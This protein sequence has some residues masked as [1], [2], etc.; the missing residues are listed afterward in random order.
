[1][2]SWKNERNYISIPEKFIYGA[3]GPGTAWKAVV[4]EH[5]KTTRNQAR[6]YEFTTIHN[7]LV[8]VDV[9]MCQRN[10]RTLKALKRV[11]YH[12]LM[13][14]DEFSIANDRPNFI[15]R[16]IPEISSTVLVLLWVCFWHSSESI[17]QT[18]PPLSN[19]TSGSDLGNDFRKHGCRPSLIDATL[20][21]FAPDI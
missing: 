21:K 10:T 5:Y 14:C 15:E 20:P 19:R 8:Y 18:K 4:I 6:E 7:R 3:A 1:L 16:S 9:D 17:K 2:A 11:W 12:A 13:V